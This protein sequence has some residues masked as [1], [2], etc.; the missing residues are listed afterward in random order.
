MRAGRI[1]VGDF[2]Q[3]WVSPFSKANY[4]S[5]VPMIQGLF[6][7]EK[8]VSVRKLREELTNLIGR[9]FFNQYTLE[10]SMVEWDLRTV[11][12]VIAAAAPTWFKMLKEGL[13]VARRKRAIKDS[14]E[15]IRKHI[16]AITSIVVHSIALQEASWVPKA[17]RV[18][19]VCSGVKRCV[20]SVLNNIGLVSSFKTIQRVMKENAK[21]QDKAVRKMAKDPQTYII[22][23]HFNRPDNR[24]DQV[25]GDIN[26]QLNM[27][28]SFISRNLD[29]PLEGLTIDMLKFD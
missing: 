15:V 2:I 27:T 5:R 25:V 22:Y 23:D 28:T 12:D 14:R 20:I 21:A 19:L 3:R 17:L 6:L 4:R 8:L 11:E 1:T 7:A 9:D 29:M 10:E 13:L 24:R 18:F 26:A 16:T